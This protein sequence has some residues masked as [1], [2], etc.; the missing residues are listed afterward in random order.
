MLGKKTWQKVRVA[1][2]AIGRQSPE[3]ATMAI[4]EYAAR[5]EPRSRER[6]LAAARLRRVLAKAP[7]SFIRSLHG[8]WPDGYVKDVIYEFLRPIFLR[9]EA[10]YMVQ[11]R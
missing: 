11:R 4:L 3:K 5:Y 9:D 1:L 6:K 2:R 10:Y 8:D 7:E